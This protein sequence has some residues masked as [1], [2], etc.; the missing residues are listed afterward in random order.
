MRRTISTTAT[1]AMLLGLM[2]FGL[3]APAVADVTCTGTIG[4]QTIGDNVIV[5]DGAQCT[6]DGT[7][8]DGNVLVGRSAQLTARNVTIDGNIQD[9]NGNAGNVTVTNSRVNGNI[10]L[11]QGTSVTVTGTDIDGDLQLES[12]RGALRSDG[13]EIGGN[14]QANQNT[15]GLTINGNTID[16]NLQCQSNNPPPTGGGNAV[17][18]NAEGQCANLTGGGSTPPP[19][20]SRETSRIAGGTRIET[21]VRVAQAA[22]PQGSDVVYLARADDFPDALAGGSLRNGPILLVPSCGNVPSVVL[23]EIARLD[24]A[25]VIAL[26]GSAA[27]CD[28]VLNAAGNA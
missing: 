18:G 27:I 9:D 15:G 1:I 25:R 10:Q 13:N 23:Q 7:T 24:P 12:N 21:A 19:A 28:A 11:E 20:T 17:R 16:G 22:Y 3:A 26:G 5:P 8:V 4:A 6:L 14:L 2:A